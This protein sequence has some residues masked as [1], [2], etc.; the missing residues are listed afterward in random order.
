[1]NNYDYMWDFDVLDGVE[2]Q[3][4]NRVHPLMQRRVQ[5]ILNSLKEDTNVKKI[6][7]FGS[8]IEFRCNS[9]SDID[10]YIE[11]YDHEKPL[12]KNFEVDCEVDL[13]FDL[14]HDSRLY[15]E[16]DKKGL[17]LFERK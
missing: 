15:Q 9:Y 8:S 7:L 13:L 4:C 6:V 12:E 10:L 17:L 16:I 5:S 3:C 1:M 11:K 14:E 2:F